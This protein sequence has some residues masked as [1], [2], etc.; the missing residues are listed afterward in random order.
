MAIRE[1]L[2]RN[3]DTDLRRLAEGRHHDPHSVLGLHEDGAKASVWVHIPFAQQVRIE[4]RLVA[5]RLPGTDFFVWSGARGDIPK[6]YRVMWN[7]SHGGSFDLVDPYSFA[8]VLD[9]RE[10]ASFSRGEHRAAWRFLGAHVMSSD[11]VAGVR[12]AVWAP[13]AE[14]V[15]VVGPFCRWDGRRYP[16][17]V[18]GTS[19][20]WELFIPGLGASEIY[21]FE[22]RSRHS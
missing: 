1:S 20:V 5:E 15:S 3:L 18:S 7:D 11:G 6:H 14:R 22:I 2:R 19:G 10:I 9:A 21:K 8:P 13:D 16:M 4:G 17:R 12:F